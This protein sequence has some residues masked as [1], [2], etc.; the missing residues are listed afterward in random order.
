MVGKLFPA[1]EILEMALRI[2]HHGVAF[3]QACVEASPG[4][5]Q[6]D[7]FQYLIE[8]EHNHIETFSRMK[9][10]AEDYRLPESYAG[11]SLSYVKSFIKDSVFTDPAEGAQQAADMQDPFEV[12]EYAIGFEKASILFYS[13]LQQFVRSSERE[14]LESII[15]EEHSHIEKLLALREQIE[16]RQA[17]G[18]QTET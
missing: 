7:I 3:Y 9:E 14:T 13:S 11:E 10:E 5:E 16:N 6:R 18:G 15:A 2:E 12:I 8:Q 17:E 1:D 4:P